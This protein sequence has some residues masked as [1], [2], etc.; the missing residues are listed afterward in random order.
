MPKNV[1]TIVVGNENQLNF[2]G[3]FILFQFFERA[4]LQLSPISMGRND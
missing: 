4:I 3:L 1:S 2:D